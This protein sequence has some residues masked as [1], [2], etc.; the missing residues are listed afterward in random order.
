MPLIG[1]PGQLQPMHSRDTVGLRN[2]AHLVVMD[3]V[4][5]VVVVE[6]AAVAIVPSVPA[7]PS[8]VAREISAG[9]MRVPTIV[10]NPPLPRLLC[11]KSM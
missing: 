11:R 10:A 6:S 9:G 1:K 4:A 7:V 8:L 3:P 2:V 5:V